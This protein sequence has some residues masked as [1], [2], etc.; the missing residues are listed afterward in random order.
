VCEQRRTNHQDDN[1]RNRRALLPQL[2]QVSNIFVVASILV[3]G[4]RGLFNT[5]WQGWHLFVTLKDGD[6]RQ[7][8]R[9]SIAVTDDLISKKGRRSYLLRKSHD[10]LCWSPSRANGLHVLRPSS[11]CRPF[12]IFAQP[13]AASIVTAAKSI[14]PRG[15]V[16]VV[17]PRR[18]FSTSRANDRF[19]RYGRPALEDPAGARAY[20][21]AAAAGSSKPCGP[22][23]RLG[24]CR[25]PNSGCS[26]R[27]WVVSEAERT[28]ATRIEVS[29]KVCFVGRP[30]QSIHP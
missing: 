18:L 27:S 22:Q 20:L 6:F 10:G 1:W 25:M 19:P 23:Q 21:Q 24:L 12:S 3:G 29:V 11:V 9:A 26:R 2:S 13:P 30:R 4:R 17:G 5:R 16:P 7:I 8:G 15:H 28:H 14:S